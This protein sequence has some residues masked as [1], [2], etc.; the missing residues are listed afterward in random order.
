MKKMTVLR[1]KEIHNRY[2]ELMK[3]PSKMAFKEALTLLAT[4]NDIGESYVKNILKVHGVIGTSKVD[5]DMSPRDSRIIEMYMNGDD[6]SVISE[7]FSLTTTRIGQIIRGHLGKNA[8]SGILEKSLIGLKV[9]INKGMDHKTI[10]DKY[11]ASLL[12][13]IKSNLGYN[14]FD[15]CLDKRNKDIHIMYQGHNDKVLTEFINKSLIN[16]RLPIFEELYTLARDKFVEDFESLDFDN[17]YIILLE[18]MDGIGT[19]ASGNVIDVY[20]VIKPVVFDGDP[21]DEPDDIDRAEDVLKCIQDI[22]K[23]ENIITNLIISVVK[24]QKKFTA[25][26]ISIIWSLTRDHVYGILHEFGERSKPTVSEYK[27]RNKLIVLA[28]KDEKKTSQDIADEHDMT[29]TNVNI[30]LKN[31]GARE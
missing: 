27:K 16:N 23:R 14:A 19:D 21:E 11:G 5:G 29:V 3:K 17:L 18:K 28:F 2:K 13:K 7:E 31:H 24:G 1:Y 12:R 30:I 22:K 10:Q 6:H 8:K 9:D 26:E 15:A 20:D 25:I 4:E